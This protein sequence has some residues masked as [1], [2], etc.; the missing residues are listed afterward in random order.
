MKEQL[1]NRTK[2]YAA[3][4]RPLIRCSSLVGVNYRAACRAKSTADFVYKLKIVEEEA[5][6]L[7]SIIVASIKTVK[8]RQSNKSSI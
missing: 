5:N 7:V 3:F 2:E 4:C 6:E 1:K 8:N